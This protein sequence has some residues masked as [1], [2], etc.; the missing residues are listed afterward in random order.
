MQP[1]AARQVAEARWVSK[2]AEE[3]GKVAACLQY[4]GR[5]W[6]PLKANGK[7]IPAAAAGRSAAKYHP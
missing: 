4:R 2:Q 3:G 7:P 6:P 5:L 1:A